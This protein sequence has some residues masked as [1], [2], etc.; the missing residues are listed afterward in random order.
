MRKRWKEK[1]RKSLNV[2]HDK[3]GIGILEMKNGRPPD[4]NE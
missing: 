2:D 1:I 4:L 3:M